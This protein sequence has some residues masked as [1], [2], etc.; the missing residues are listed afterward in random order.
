MSSTTTNP[1][2]RPYLEQVKEA[3]EQLG[4]TEGPLK[5][6]GR[7]SLR[8]IKT[9]VA[10][11]RCVTN[12]K[13]GVFLRGLRLA[14]GSDELEKDGQSYRVRAAQKAAKAEH[15]VKKAAS[16]APE[17]M[18][19]RAPGHP[20]THPK[21]G[22]CGVLE[23]RDNGLIKKFKTKAGVTVS[24]RANGEVSSARGLMFSASSRG[25]LKVKPGRRS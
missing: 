8:A 17:W 23:V 25:G 24:V 2:T 7:V 22:V 13:D 12:L 5:Y 14:L 3:I 18:S 21:Y 10:D 19:F 20:F 16:N 6:R 11:L 1:D 4:V 15:K 9:Y